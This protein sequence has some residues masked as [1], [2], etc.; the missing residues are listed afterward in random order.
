MAS[1]A[2]IIAEYAV[3]AMISK[4]AKHAIVDNGGDIAIFSDKKIN[5]GIYIFQKLLL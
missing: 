3:K 2:G 4:G 1:V 5:V